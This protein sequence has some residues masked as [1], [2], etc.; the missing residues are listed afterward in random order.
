MIGTVGRPLAID[1]LTIADSS[2]ETAQRIARALVFWQALCG[3][4]LFAATWRLWWPGSEFPQI[5]W[6]AWGLS[7]PTWIDAVACVVLVGSL[8]CLLISLS[9][10]LTLFW[11]S[12]SSWERAGVRGITIGCLFSLSFLVVLDQHRLQPWVWQMLLWCVVFLATPSTMLWCLRWLTVSIYFWSGISKLDAAFVQ[13]DSH[14]WLL[15]EGLTRA[16]RIDTQFWQPETM[17]NLAMLFPWGELL[18]AVWLAG[19]MLIVI[20]FTR[21]HG[22]PA[23]SLRWPSRMLRAGCWPT[24]AMHLVLMLIVGPLGLN[25]EPGVLVW[26]VFFVGQAWLLFFAW[27]SPDQIEGEK[28]RRS[29]GENVTIAP[30]PVSPGPL[31]PLSRHGGDMRSCIQDRVITACTLIAMIYP[32]LSFWGRCDHWPAWS[33]YSSRPAIVEVW[34]DTDTVAD[35]PPELQSFLAP[36]PPLET[37]REFNLDAWS[38]RELGCPLYPQERYRLALAREFIARH[39]LA[40]HTIVRVQSTPDWW[41]GERRLE[42]LDG[43]DLDSRLSGYA[44]NTQAR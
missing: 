32:I 17:S 14:G 5:P 19:W 3:L 41:T 39:S 33:V 23:P 38:Y 9:P 24:I 31:V 29:E 1:H 22:D 18:I 12:R 21:D 42:E 25:H 26:N 15:L 10:P 7:V 11:K 40:E 28:E 8:I 13:S 4:V 36:A 44:W 16:L 27:P 6:F 37:R 30:V 35:L 20:T 34:I 43:A 2:D